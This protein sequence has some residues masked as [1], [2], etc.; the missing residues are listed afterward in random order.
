MKINF[1]NPCKENIKLPFMHLFE[2]D[3]HK[4]RQNMSKLLP[5]YRDDLGN[6]I[7]HYACMYHDDMLLE[8]YINLIDINT[9]NANHETPLELAI[10]SHLNEGFTTYESPKNNVW[11]IFEK[12]RTAS[13]KL[14]E[15]R[16]NHAFFSKLVQAGA[17]INQDTAIQ[18]LMEVYASHRTN[19]DIHSPIHDSYIRSFDAL[20]NNEVP[21]VLF[22]GVRK[23]EDLIAI[24]PLF[25]KSTLGFDQQDETGKTL[26]HYVCSAMQHIQEDPAPIVVKKDKNIS[27]SNIQLG[28]HM[29]I[30]GTTGSGMSHS[31][32]GMMRMITFYATTFETVYDKI[33]HHPNMQQEYLY[34]K[35]DKGNSVYDDLSYDNYYK[36]KTNAFYLEKVLP[37]NTN[38]KKQRRIKV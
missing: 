23:N 36:A 17:I 4:A 7:L 13:Y 19:K 8:K 22:D 32:G 11:F 20:Y 3:A 35:D 33:L 21:S 5:T 26:L 30:M 12:Y 34:I 18:K 2:N 10:K 29:L 15:L 6:T 38:S 31:M 28:Y 1:S 37:L 16:Y 25:D 24:M 9:L 27:V 14:P